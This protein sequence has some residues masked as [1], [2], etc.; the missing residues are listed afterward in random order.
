MPSSPQST[1]NDRAAPPPPALEHPRRRAGAVLALLA[2][3]QF[4]VVLNASSVNLALPSLIGDLGASAS[5]SVWVV[6]AYL[7]TF[8]ALLLFGGR[9]GD[10]IGRRR[11][12]SVSAGLFGAA[13]LAGGLAPTL[14]TL[15][16]ARAVQ[17]A[18]AAG[19]APTALSL[20]TTLFTDPAAR[21]RAIGVWGAVASSGG[22]AGVLVG[23][24]FTAAWGWRAV[25]LVNVPLIVLMLVAIPLL[26]PAIPRGPAQRLDVS[27]AVLS[28]LGISALIGGLTLGNEQG[29]LSPIT[30]GLLGGGA[31]LLTA[32]GLTERGKQAPLIPAHLLRRWPSTGGNIGMVLIA[33]ALYPTMLLLSLI[34]QG[35]LGFSP[36]GAGL[37]MLPM[38]LATIGAALVTPRLVAVRGPLASLFIGL[39]LLGLA[40]ATLALVSALGAP[41]AVLVAATVAFGA[42]VGI[43]V[44]SATTQALAGASP[45]EA[46][47]VSGL[48]QTA[49]QLGGAVG[50][51]VIGA[52]AAA[53]T[54][55]LRGTGT[56]AVDTGYGAALGV[57][58]VVVLGGLLVLAVR[59]RRSTPASTDTALG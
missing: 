55:S 50:L 6:S 13:A 17:G 19:L 51:T 5:L 52:I 56:G 36:I 24:G 59:Q 21:R 33:V 2:A 11:M 20:L 23:G 47:S 32:F 39:A 28:F 9:L 10:V 1:L 16:A 49:Q 15:I 27:G 46:G 43:A 14:E 29:W 18:A 3:A 8:G 26:I 53:V 41:S 7:L 38:S 58:A 30:L 42:A 22:A 48:I 45:R 37:M 25:L 44:T 31:V 35:S 12:F 40:T 57:A 34:L 4:V 54:G